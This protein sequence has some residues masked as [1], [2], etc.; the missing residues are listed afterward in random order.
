MLSRYGMGDCKPVSTP[1]DPG[2]CLS[3]DDG[4]KTDEERTLMRS[5]DYG[6][7]LGSLQYLSCTTHPDIAIYSV[8]QLASFTSNPG[9]AH[10][11]IGTSFATSREPWT[12]VSSMPLMRRFLSCSPLTLM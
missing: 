9:V 6:G 11:N 2:L 4:P 1:M 5:V 7:A 8:G 12:M 10:W 3:R